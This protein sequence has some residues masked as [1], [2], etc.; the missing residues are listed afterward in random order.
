MT[1]V[2][3]ARK[4]FGLSNE[5]YIVV[6]AENET[7]RKQTNDW[8]VFELLECRDFGIRYNYVFLLEEYKKQEIL[9]EEKKAELEE[10]KAK[11]REAF[12]LLRSAEAARKLKPLVSL[13]EKMGVEFFQADEM[14]GYEYI[15]EKYAE[16]R[17][18]LE[19]SCADYTDEIDFEAPFNAIKEELNNIRNTYNEMKLAFENLENIKYNY[20]IG[21]D[22][23]GYGIRIIDYEHALKLAY[24]KRKR[25]IKAEEKEREAGKEPAPG[26]RLKY[27]KAEEKP[28]RIYE[29]NFR[30]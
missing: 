20:E 30:Y 6:L 27:Y 22:Y 13:Y 23:G 9:L 4:T 17:R 25:A 21:L 3:K 19:E 8:V 12:R 15:M 2:E 24:S 5:E 7:I 11:A 16:A 26:E 14:T 10:C 28:K 18:A 1:Y 29:P